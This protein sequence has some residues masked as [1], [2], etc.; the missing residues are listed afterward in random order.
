M[1]FERTEEQEMLTD[2]LTRFVVDAV[3]PRATAWSQAG[4]MPPDALEGLRDLGLMGLE[5]SESMG[6]AGFGSVE[7]VQS[8]ESLAAGDGGLALALVVHSVAASTLA[9]DPENYGSV[10]QSLAAGESYATL[11]WVD[12]PKN[13]MTAHADGDDLVLKGTKEAVAIA[14]R[15]GWVLLRTTSDEEQGLALVA[16]DTAGV[17]IEPVSHALGLRSAGLATLQCENVRIAK[18]AWFGSAALEAAQVHL[19]L[20]MAALAVGLGAACL[21]EGAQ[22]GMDRK[23][24]GKPIAMFQANQFK[25][26]DMLTENDGARLLVLRAALSKHPREVDMARMFATDSAFKAADHALQLHGGYG[27]TEEFPVERF[28]RDAQFTTALF[29]T[30][31]MLRSEIATKLLEEV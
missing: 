11:G 25:L 26:A 17:S 7:W 21:S 8:V 27:F 10:V 20:G 23:Q 16:L 6:G 19:D 12:S 28:Y 13:P 29:R 18:T 31:D 15:A 4:Q 2:T 30:G 1:L 24:F 14:E 22:Y 9:R 3:K 5:L